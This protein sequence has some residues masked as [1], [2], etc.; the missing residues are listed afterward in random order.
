LFGIGEDPDREGL[1]KT[2]A[3]VARMYAELF[4]GL[5]KDPAEHV[6]AAFTECYDELVVLHRD[7]T[8]IVDAIIAMAHSLNLKVLAEGVE[9]KEQLN[10]LKMRNCDEAQGYYFSKPL[11]AEVV[12]RMNG[13]QRNV[14]TG[15]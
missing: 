1:R 12:Y 10:Y 9:T 2:P 7:D 6:V 15:S 11:K 4:A 8:A 13:T 3:R 5:D 14:Q